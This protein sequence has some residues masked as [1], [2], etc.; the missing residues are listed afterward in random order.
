[1]D[2]TMWGP[3]NLDKDKWHEF[4]LHIVWSTCKNFNNDGKCNDTKNPG[5]IELWVDGDHNKISNR[6]TLDDDG[7][8]YLK[9][10]LYFCNNVTNPGKCPYVNT[11]PPKTIIHDGMEYISC[12]DNFKFKRLIC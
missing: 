3:V 11:D 6:Y 10:G 12:T 8:V 5:L 7:Q 4:M 2:D 9:Q 1:M